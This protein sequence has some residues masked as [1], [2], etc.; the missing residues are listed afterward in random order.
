MNPLLNSTPCNVIAG[1]LHE[2]SSAAAHVVKSRTDGTPVEWRL[3]AHG[4]FSITKDG[5]TVSGHYCPEHSDAILAYAEKKG[6]QIPIDSEH[7]LAVLADKL[8][9]DEAELLPLLNRSKVT[10][11]Y[12]SLQKRED[13]LWLTAVEWLPLARKIVAE[14]VLRWFSPV[15]RG[16]LDGRLRITSVALTNTPALDRLDAIAASAEADD[17]PGSH[18]RVAS[19]PSSVSS[20]NQ[21]QKGTRAPMNELLK[22]LATLAGIPDA[23]AA[24]LTADTAEA[25]L[26]PKLQALAAEAAAQKA[27][28]AAQTAILADLRGALALSAESAPE[29]VKGAV[30]ALVEKSKSDT[31]TLSAIQTRVQALEAEKTARERQALIDG[32]LAA[33]KLTPALVESWAKNQD[34]AVLSAYLAAAPVIVQPGTRVDAVKLAQ[35]GAATVTAAQAKVFSLLGITDPEQ[36]KAAA[37]L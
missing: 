1:G 2:L 12:G 32:A 13:G 23:D 9:V 27:A 20:P 22:K 16:L 33:G 35:D 5:V 11:G 25:A 7:G 10:L 34:V 17:E 37:R 14:G 18:T 36:Q 4:P 28:G 6:N 29:A 15:I 24:A 21:P 8:G 3:F 19:L 31:A 30:L 26:L